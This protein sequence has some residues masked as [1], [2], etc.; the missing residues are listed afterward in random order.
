MLTLPGAT[1][2]NG[3]LLAGQRVVDAQGHGHPRQVMSRPICPR[4]TSVPLVARRS[5]LSPSR[6]A[7]RPG[8]RSPRRGRCGRPS[9]RSWPSRS[10]DHRH[11]S[12]PGQVLADRRLDRAELRLLGEDVDVHIDDAVAQLRQLARGRRP[13]RSASRGPCSPGSVSGKASPMSPRPAAP[14]RAS[15]TA[16]STTSA[17]LWPARPR[18]CSIAHAA[19]DERPAGPRRWVSWPMPTRSCGDC[20][21]ARDLRQARLQTSRD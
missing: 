10:R 16:C 8:S 11:A 15:V 4:V 12:K 13:G 6:S 21:H 7:R 5:S 17:S 1:V 19:Q 9:R 14:S 18:G 3:F 20:T 2:W